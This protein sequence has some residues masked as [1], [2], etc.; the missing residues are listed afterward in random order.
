MAACGR[1]GMQD[2]NHQN[3]LF[4]FLSFLIPLCSKLN[5]MASSCQ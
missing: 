4:S 3:I 2:G 1:T 5:L